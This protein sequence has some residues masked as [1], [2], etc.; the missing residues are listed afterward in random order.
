MHLLIGRH[1]IAGP[2][3]RS[4]RRKLDKE[5]SIRGGKHTE[6]RYVFTIWSP[7]KFDIIGLAIS[8]REN[9]SN[10]IE[11]KSHEKS[12]SQPQGSTCW[13]KV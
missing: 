4:D 7:R 11:I 2:S 9:E 5:G 1:T 10:Q 13:W 12:P 3:E 8:R 6:T